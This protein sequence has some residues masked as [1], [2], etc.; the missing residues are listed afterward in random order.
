M[1]IL[2]RYCTGTEGVV[3][4]RNL[5][6]FP[7]SS[8]TTGAA[9]TTSALADFTVAD[10]LDGTDG[11]TVASTR[12]STSLDGAT[13]VVSAGAGGAGFCLAVLGVPVG[14]GDGDGDDGSCPWAWAWLCCFCCRR[15]WGG[16]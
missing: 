7:A 9:P 15:T 12:L 10:G 5:S 14:D 6:R 16:L 13:A 1:L 2:G 3:E 4:L 11:D 8:A